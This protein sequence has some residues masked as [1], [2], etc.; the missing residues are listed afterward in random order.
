MRAFFV[1]GTLFFRPTS[2]EEA[3]HADHQCRRHQAEFDE[4][5]ASVQNDPI[6]VQEN[7]S[8]VA[9]ILSPDLY[10]FLLKEPPA[11]VNPRI[12]ALFKRSMVERRQVYR[13]LAKYEAEHPETDDD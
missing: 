2:G 7:G 8:D 10:D 4:V 12:A 6:R 11:S 1:C 3:G 5:I 9:I 13:A